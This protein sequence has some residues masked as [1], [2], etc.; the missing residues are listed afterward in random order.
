MLTT[1]NGGLAG[2]AQC[3]TSDW[4][5]R[6][7]SL[8]QQLASGRW[9]DVPALVQA[10]AAALPSGR[11]SVHAAAAALLGNCSAAHVVARAMRGDGLEALA[12]MVP[13][14]LSS[15]PRMAALAVSIG[16]AAGQHLE[17]MPWMAKDV[18][19]VFVDSR[20]GGLEMAQVC[21]RRRWACPLVLSLLPS[22]EA[23]RATCAVVSLFALTSGMLG[24]PDRE[25]HCN[26]LTASGTF[27]YVPACATRQQFG[28]RSMPCQASTSHQFI[29]SGPPTALPPLHAPPPSRPGLPSTTTLS[30]PLPTPAAQPRSSKQ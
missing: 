6:A 5:G 16:L 22:S 15:S 19:F 27:M 2:W 11:P 8:H 1:A 21:G 28:K 30:T 17:A 14:D 7:H 29:F 12:V 25:H 4:L 20:C 26:K 10:A 13:I 23:R 24:P 18:L 3:R 9:E